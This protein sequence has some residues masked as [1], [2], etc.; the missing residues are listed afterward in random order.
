MKQKKEKRRWITWDEIKQV[1]ANT[2]EHDLKEVRKILDS[3]SPLWLKLI[4]H[5]KKEGEKEYER[6]E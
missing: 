6:N 4:K 1:L 3:P 2:R 5:T